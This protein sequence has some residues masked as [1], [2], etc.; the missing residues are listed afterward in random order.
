MPITFYRCQK[1]K[2]EFIDIQD[3]NN[4]EAAHPEPIA[5]KTVQY[6]IKNWPYSVEVT[7]NNRSK[8]IYNADDMGG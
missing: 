1:C 2:R 6:S 4:C 5:V 7:F 8:R 3:A